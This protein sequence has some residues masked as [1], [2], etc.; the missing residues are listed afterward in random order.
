MGKMC[1]VLGDGDE[2]FVGIVCFGLWC[3]LLW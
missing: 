3:L 1:L 2:F